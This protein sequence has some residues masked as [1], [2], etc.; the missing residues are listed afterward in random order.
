MKHFIYRMKVA[1]VFMSALLTC[2]QF[3]SCGSIDNGRGDS[4]SS[5]KI[6]IFHSLKLKFSQNGDMTVFLD[7]KPMK[8]LPE[9]ELQLVSMRSEIETREFKII[10][11]GNEVG[12]AIF[13]PPYSESGIIELL[14]DYKCSLSYFANGRPIKYHVLRWTGYE[15]NLDDPE[16]AIFTLNGAVISK[17]GILDLFQDNKIKKGECLQVF[18]PWAG[19][20]LSRLIPR[21]PF[22]DSEVYELSIK[23]GVRL[24]YIFDDRPFRIKR[25]M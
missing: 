23:K 12:S 17:Q 9:A 10:F 2:C 4:S 20:A 13:R 21:S 16:K 1:L 19:P 3:M 15:S 14:N 11:I 7:D 5:G 6:G 18:F 25:D 8:G 24:D 22:D